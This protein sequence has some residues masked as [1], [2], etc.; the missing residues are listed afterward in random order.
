VQHLNR[1]LSEVDKP[2]SVEVSPAVEMVCCEK[3]NTLLNLGHDFDK[4]FGLVH[5]RG[6]L[7]LL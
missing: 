2:L 7:K 5:N 4:F 6:T 1:L 3:V